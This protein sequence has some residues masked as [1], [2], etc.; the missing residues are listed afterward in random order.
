MK[1]WELLHLT[2]D[3]SKSDKEQGDYQDQKEKKTFKTRRVQ[4]I[5]CEFCAEGSSEGRLI[6]EMSSEFVWSS[7]F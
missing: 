7:N 3:N 5:K 6:S 1:K 2:L 4:V